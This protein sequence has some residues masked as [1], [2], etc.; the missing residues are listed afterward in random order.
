ME[1]EAAPYTTGHLQNLFGW[2]YET[3]RRYCKEFADWL[4]PT[5]TPPPNDHRK[6][7]Y[8]DLKVFALIAEMKQG[9]KTYT[10]IK[11]ALGTGQRGTLPELS[12]DEIKVIHMTRQGVQIFARMQGRIEEL[13]TAL[14]AEQRKIIPM[15][16]RI[17][18]LEAQLRLL[19]EQLQAVDDRILSAYAKG[20]NYGMAL[21]APKPTA[22]P[23]AAPPE[24]APGQGG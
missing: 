1:N 15:D 10:D 17:I 14:K 3:V 23:P 18:E 13:E 20:V 5:A 7:T 4:S 9:R 19:K 21:S 11:L 16:G 24:P 12:E 8:D 6:F 2:H 22:D